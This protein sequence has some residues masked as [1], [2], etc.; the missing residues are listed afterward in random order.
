MRITGTVGV[1][2]VCLSEVIKGVC[3]ISSR[4]SHRGID[5]GEKGVITEIRAM[6]VQDIELVG[7]LLMQLAQDL[8]QEFFMDRKRLETHLQ[9]M[10]DYAD[11]YG[12]FVYSLD[13]I[14]VGFVS[15]VMYR[16]LFHRN[17]TA[18]INEL[19][20]SRAYRGGHIG[21]A[22]VRHAGEFARN[23]GMDELEV[24]VMQEN[25]RAQQFYR[26]NGFDIE[27][28]LLGKNLV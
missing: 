17:G 23:C 22:L 1:T 11:I 15:L 24:G 3:R 8:N 19:V 27:Y 12:N 20:V 28:L 2:M 14:I 25:H 26:R 21:S 10:L 18:L 9:T 5:M 7:E 13:G 4:L 16:S 6:E